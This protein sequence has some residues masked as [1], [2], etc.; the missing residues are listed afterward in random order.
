MDS[1]TTLQ[2]ERHGPAAVLMRDRVA[3]KAREGSKDSGRIVDIINLIFESCDVACPG[4]EPL[5]PKTLWKSDSK[6]A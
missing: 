3:H 4:L 5:N 1:L 6:M 2:F